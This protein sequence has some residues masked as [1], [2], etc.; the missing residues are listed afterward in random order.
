MWG[1][2]HCYPC[3]IAD[4]Y[5]MLGK[6][7]AYNVGIWHI[8]VFYGFVHLHNMLVAFVFIVRIV[9]HAT[10]LKQATPVWE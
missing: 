8:M 2:F 7:A 3:A 5:I 9:S 6:Y 1:V 10:K 4:E